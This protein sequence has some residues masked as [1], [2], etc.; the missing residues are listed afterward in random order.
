[1]FCLWTD[2]ACHSL[3]TINHNCTT[4][5]PL[6]LLQVHNLKTDWLIVTVVNQ[7]LVCAP[8]EAQVGERC[9]VVINCWQTVTCLIR[10]KTKHGCTRV[11]YTV[12]RLHAHVYL[13]QAHTWTYTDI[14]LEYSLYII[15]LLYTHIYCFILY[16]YIY[17]Y[18]YIYYY[19]IAHSV[20]P[21]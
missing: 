8:E 12:V 13:C 21:L 20:K 3:S 18:I 14:I 11:Q 16:Y 15:I 1:M 2:K 5:C 6:G 19:Y 7:C 10:P 4:F 9:T 17:I